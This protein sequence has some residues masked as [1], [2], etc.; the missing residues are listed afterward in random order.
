MRIHHFNTESSGGAYTYAER[1][2]NALNETGHESVLHTRLSLGES[3]ICGWNKTRVFK[4]LERARYSVENRLLRPGAPSYYSRLRQCHTTPTPAQDFDIVHLHWVGRWLDLNSFMSSIPRH[5]PVVW[6]VHD[7]S[8]LAGGCFTSFGCGEFG[9][10]CRKCPLLKAPLD[11]LLA[12]QELRRRREILCG[13]CVAFVANSNSTLEMV[14]RSEVAS[15]HP[16]ECI[17]PGFDFSQ[18]TAIEKSFAKARWGLPA[19]SFV[20]GFVAASLTDEN[21]GISRF[22]EVVGEVAKQV[23]QTHA[24]L[25]GEGNPL[26]PLATRKTG[27]IGNQQDLNAAYSAMD[28]LIITSKMESFGQVSVEAQAC[29]TP[30][31]VYNVGGVG[32]TLENGVSGGLAEFA[33]FADLASRINEAKIS[34]KLEFMGV[35]GREKCYEKY[36]I[37]K[38][39]EKYIDLYKKI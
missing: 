3:S 31:W 29:G 11:S 12:R 9:K 34:G 32:E 6:T 4:T 18:F 7:M 38:F 26:Q 17:P 13:R 35:K 27:L 37:K 21:K 23:P 28:A 39:V 30:V 24:L 25:V 19:D 36:N 20:L 22:Y 33:Q 8:P 1:L 2:S 16:V 10:G 5:V 14:R 15:G